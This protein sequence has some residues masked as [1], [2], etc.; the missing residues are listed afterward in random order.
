VLSWLFFHPF[1]LFC[2]FWKEPKVQ[3]FR[4]ILTPTRIMFSDV[5]NFQELR[6]DSAVYLDSH[7]FHLF[8]LSKHEF[9]VFAIIFMENSN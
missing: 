1:F 4:T 9:C 8:W 3:D 7:T 6:L 5:R 2:S